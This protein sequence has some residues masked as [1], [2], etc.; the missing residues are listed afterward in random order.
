MVPNVVIPKKFKVLKFIQYTRLECPN[1]HLRLYCNK[2]VEVIH[3]DKFIQDSLS[4]SALSSYMALDNTRV[5]KWS[6]LTDAFLRKYKFNIDIALD[7]TSLMVME[8]G[9]KETVREFTH[10]WNNKALH[11]QPSLLEKEMMT[12][13]ANTFKSPYYEYLIGSSA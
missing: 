10:R 12:L 13:F 7:Q 2:M 4:G 11:V 1:I 3:N 8:K 5:K 9:N 6:D